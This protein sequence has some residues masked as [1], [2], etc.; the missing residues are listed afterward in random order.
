MVHAI[1]GLAD[2]LGLSVVAEGVE[3]SDQL[4][5]LRALDCELGQ[6]YLWSPAV[7]ADEVLAVAERIGRG[8]QN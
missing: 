8:E 2:V 3:T 5:A 7:P 1:V 6:G 4:D